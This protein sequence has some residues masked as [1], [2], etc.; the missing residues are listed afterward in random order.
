MSEQRLDTLTRWINYHVSRGKGTLIKDIDHNLDDGTV[1]CI[2]VG[3]LFRGAAVDHN[4]RPLDETQK[5]DNIVRAIRLAKD[6]GVQVEAGLVESILNHERNHVVSFLMSLVDKV[7][8]RRV[9]DSQHKTWKDAKGSFGL[10]EWSNTYLDGDVQVND[11]GLS[12]TSGIALNMICKKIAGLPLDDNKEKSASELID[13][14]I[15]IAKHKLHVPRIVPPSVFLDPDEDCIF[16]YLSLLYSIQ[17]SLYEHNRRK[18]SAAFQS[19]PSVVARRSIFEGNAPIVSPVKFKRHSTID[20]ELPRQNSGDQSRP[21][22]LHTQ[23]PVENCEDDL[24]LPDHTSGAQPDPELELKKEVKQEI[25]PPCLGAEASD[26]PKQKASSVEKTAVPEPTAVE[27]QQMPKGDVVVAKG[28]RQGTSQAESSE[29]MESESKS[30]SNPEKVSG[31]ETSSSSLIH[32]EDT[33]KVD[34]AKAPERK[35]A[36]KPMLIRVSTAEEE[37]AKHVQRMI[38]RRK[39]TEEQQQ[40]Q[41]S[42]NAKDLEKTIEETLSVHSDQSSPTN[43]DA[44]TKS[45]FSSQSPSNA[46]VSMATRASILGQTQVDVDFGE[47]EDDT[48]IPYVSDADLADTGTNSLFRFKASNSV[49]VSKPLETPKEQPTHAVREL[50]TEE[51]T[52]DS[53]ERQ[54]EHRRRSLPSSKKTFVYESLRQGV[55]VKRH[56][57]L[58]GMYQ[59]MWLSRNRRHL[60]FGKQTNRGRQVY[61]YI[62]IAAIRYLICKGAT[63]LSLHHDS[64][65]WSM[66]LKCLVL[67]FESKQERDFWHRSIE[68]SVI[69]YYESRRLRIQL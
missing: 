36:R 43:K 58:T 2:L 42:E 11:M 69:R 7:T 62:D 13:D 65:V 3:Q 12:W 24:A 31:N 46:E 18:D 59:I 66:K 16:L 9:I 68:Y 8:E 50:L 56:Y 55:T 67:D 26:V 1:L 61:D 23:D 28:E 57:F 20:I 60:K 10:L 14:A 41:K 19:L 63:Q 54:Q 49:K 15:S 52:K 48:T 22:T 53:Q 47:F 45:S 32:N 44:K 29:P 30:Q 4:E 5:R 25:S 40:H 21:A 17:Q 27:P 39:A 37:E 33:G 51:F 38:V 6:N 35:R 64:F 34:K